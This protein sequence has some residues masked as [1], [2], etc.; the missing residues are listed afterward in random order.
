MLKIVLLGTSAFWASFILYIAI[1]IFMLGTTQSV[2]GPR[3]YKPVGM[4]RVR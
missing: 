3:L 1:P 2:H 4:R